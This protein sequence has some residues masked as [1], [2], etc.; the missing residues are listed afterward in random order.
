MTRF[1]TTPAFSRRDALRSAACGFGYLAMADMAHAAASSAPV[2]GDVSPLAA[3]AGHF[4][5]RA[6]RIIYIFMAGGV[7]Q[8]DSFD[9]KPLLD[10][11]DGE[12]REFHDAR[13]LAKTRS[14]AK[15]RVMKSPWSF[16]QYGQCGRWVSD[17]FPE[18]GR[19]V[20]DLCFLHGMHTEGVAH[21]PATLFLHTGT[22][23]FV[24]PSMGNGGPR[25]YGSAFLPPV[26][27]GTA[28]GRAGVPAAQSTIKNLTS[29]RRAPAEQR[30]QFD[31][32]RALNAEQLSRR[33][34]DGELEAVIDSFELAYRMQHSAPD[35]LD[36]SRETAETLAMYGIGQSETDDFGRK[37]LLA[38]R[39]AESG[40]RYVQVN[41]TDNS[42]NPAWDQHSNL[43]KHAEHARAVDRPVAAL[44]ADLKRR[45]L[46]EDTLVWW[47]SEFGRNPYAQNG[48]TGRDH[49]PD[50]FTV[51]LAGGGVK[52][53]MAHG[54]TDEW[55]HA[56]VENKVH[57]HDL[58]ATI[59][60]LLGLDHEK[61]TYRHAGRNFRLTDV[62]GTVMKDILA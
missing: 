4:A 60:R 48:G 25:N 1:A 37:C 59:L 31:L 10:A 53:G 30:A 6:K 27:Q 54:A 35:V 5:A 19:H 40:V 55:G 11:R 29:D 3:R 14:V 34:A 16:R 22:T 23:T 47:G 44:L 13:V 39:L 9:R 57:M 42:N 28:V 33:P 56:A 45:G 51:W 49:N 58:H 32:I 38:R 26:Y 36:L 52:P 15:H 43:P 20:D 17:L 12:M 8:V 62:H 2:A 41:Y 18:T 46:L 7:S 61:L 24:R 50:G 21:G